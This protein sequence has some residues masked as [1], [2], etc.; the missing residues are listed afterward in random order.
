MNENYDIVVIF[1][2]IDEIVKKLKKE[3]F[4]NVSGQG[5]KSK[6]TVS[7]LITIAIIG[8]LEQVQ[9]LKRLHRLIGC[10]LFK[11][12]FNEIPS[13]QQFC[14]SMRNLDLVINHVI[15][16]F[17][18]LN[19]SLNK[20]KNIIDGT[21]LPITKYPFKYIKWTNNTSSL[22]K[23]LGEWYQG[24]KLHLLINTDMEIINQ[25][26]K[27]AS[28]HDVNLLDSDNFLERVEGELIGDK[29]YISEA[30]KK[31]LFETKNINLITPLRENMDQSKN[32]YTKAHKNMR[33]RIETVNGVL[34]DHF[35]L[36]YKFARNVDGFFSWVKSTLLAYS[37]SI[38][39]ENS[40][41]LANFLKAL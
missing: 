23:C 15:V 5:R 33:K 35:C 24:F 1:V 3:H 32:I 2:I 34:K 7:E 20:K 26:I 6:L 25:Q 18:Q 16:L 40:D 30:K 11:S 37:F 28:V 39:C 4:L 10:V 17:A 9:S 41:K 14:I 36:L 12:Y 38:L 22:S 27:T 8:H 19:G 21:P 13:Y 31:E 29:G